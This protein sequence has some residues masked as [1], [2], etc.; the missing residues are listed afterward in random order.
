MNGFQVSRLAA[1]LVASTAL[2]AFAQGTIVDPKA[3]A[4]TTNS[5]PAASQKSDPKKDDADKAIDR[6]R[7]ETKKAPPK[8]TAKAPPAKP[9]QKKAPAK[10]PPKKVDSR[11]QPTA[12]GGT[13]QKFEAGKAPALRDA[14]GNVIP[15]S[16]DAYDISSAASPPEEK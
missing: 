2:A 3:P 8:S 4:T 6:K 15:S 11:A 9:A 12:Q 1:A 7:L 14:K 16:P 5:Q 13:V 10:A